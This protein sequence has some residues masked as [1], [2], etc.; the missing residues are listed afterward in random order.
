MSDTFNKDPQEVL[1]YSFDWSKWLAEDNDTI[2][3]HTMSAD[4]GITVDSSSHTNTKATV[5]L[6]GGA[7]DAKYQI[8]NQIVTTMGR[9]AERTMTIFVTNK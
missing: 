3:S 2:S 8:T 1:D 6:S 9:T 5:W 4:P 7:D